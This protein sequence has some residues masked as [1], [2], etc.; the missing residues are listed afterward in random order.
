V[1]AGVQ[2]LRVECEDRDEAK[3]REALHAFNPEALILTGG[4]TALFA[5][6][7]LGAHSILLKGEFAAGI[8]WGTLE[9]GEAHGRTVITKSGGFGSSSALHDLIAHL[10]GAA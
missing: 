5:G 4:D 10:S 9:D 7:A 2:I 6:Q 3:I 1:S 8:P